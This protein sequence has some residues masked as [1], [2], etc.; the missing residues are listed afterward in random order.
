[1]TMA[2]RKT[3]PLRGS[4]SSH[5]QRITCPIDEIKLDKQLELDLVEEVLVSQ[6][7]WLTL[8][9]LTGLKENLNNDWINIDHNTT[10][11]KSSKTPRGALHSYWTIFWNLGSHFLTS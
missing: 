6:F 11:R 10:K 3:L 1:M 5:E 4:Y 2:L 8:A 7:A 9:H